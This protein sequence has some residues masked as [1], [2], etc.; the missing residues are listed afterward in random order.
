MHPY[1]FLK[2]ATNSLLFF[3]VFWCKSPNFY[4]MY[5]VLCMKLFYLRD[6]YV[7]P[8]YYIVAIK[9]SIAGILTYSK[10]QNIEA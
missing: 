2:R 5:F 4:C 7:S 10:M 9:T 8:I 3:Q 6:I 1:V